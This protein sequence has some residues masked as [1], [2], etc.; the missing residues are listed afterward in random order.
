MVVSQIVQKRLTYKELTG[1]AGERERLDL[2]LWTRF[3][4]FA[5]DRFLYFASPAHDLSVQHSQ[6]F[7]YQTGG[8]PEANLPRS[9]SVAS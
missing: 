1:R 7:N 6:L 5:S 2:S 9:S 3:R 4:G 8:N